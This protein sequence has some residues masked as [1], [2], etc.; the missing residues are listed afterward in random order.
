MEKRL[1]T[2]VGSAI[3]TINPKSKGK[4]INLRKYDLVDIQMVDGEWLRAMVSDR[5]KVSGSFYNYFNIRGEDRLDRNVDLA[6]LKFKQVCEEVNMVL[7]H[8][9]K[10]QD[11]DC[12]NASE[13]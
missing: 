3:T 10:H 4:K 2:A 11:E 9:E 1:R 7:I 13:T 8:S 12:K 5:S 6:R